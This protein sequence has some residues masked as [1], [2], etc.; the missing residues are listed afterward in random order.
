M[1]PRE[2]AKENRAIIA[3]LIIIAIALV[4]VGY[5]YFAG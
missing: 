1:S 4:L 2:T 3:I 5:S